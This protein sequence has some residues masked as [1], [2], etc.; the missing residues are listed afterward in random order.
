MSELVKFATRAKFD[1]G[2]ND[3]PADNLPPNCQQ[4]LCRNKSPVPIDTTETSTDDLKFFVYPFSDK[5]TIK[6]PILPSTKDSLFG[7]KL[8]DDD[9]FGCTY[10]K[11]LSNTKTSSAAKVFGNIKRSY[12]KL[13]GAFITHINDVHVFSTIQATEQLTLF[14]N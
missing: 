12:N 5:E 2:F 6:V 14:Y 1:E 7:L 3:L 9:T 13:C 10:I 11:E 8:Q 4:I